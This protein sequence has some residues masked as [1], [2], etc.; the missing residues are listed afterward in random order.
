MLASPPKVASPSQ[1]EA[2][3]KHWNALLRKDFELTSDVLEPKALWTLLK[4]QKNLRGVIEVCLQL[5]FTDYLE[6]LLSSHRITLLEIL[7]AVPD[8]GQETKTYFYYAIRAQDQPEER[9]YF[10][11]IIG[12][13]PDLD[14]ETLTALL[15]GYQH[16]TQQE[17]SCLVEGLS[18]HWYATLMQSPHFKDEDLSSYGVDLS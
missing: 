15:T 2:S 9:R 11:S 1:L 4:T 14:E 13:L 16:L 10:L 17:K 3:H 5:N 7:Q 12:T 18:S 8:W 6:A